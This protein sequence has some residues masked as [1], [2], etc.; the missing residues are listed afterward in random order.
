MVDLLERQLFEVQAM[1]AMYSEEELQIMHSRLE[2]AQ[3]AVDAERGLE[4]RSA[5]FQP[6]SPS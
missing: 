6:L 3:A 4:S 2:Q 1:Q 5:Q